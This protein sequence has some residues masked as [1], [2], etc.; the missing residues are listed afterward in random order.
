[1]ENSKKK[2]GFRG[3]WRSQCY[4]DAGD[5]GEYIDAVSLE[6]TRL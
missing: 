5:S 3:S 4:R 1:M 6:P 2:T